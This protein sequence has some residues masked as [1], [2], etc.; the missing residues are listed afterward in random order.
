MGSLK[1]AIR[2]CNGAQVRRRYA[3]ILL[4]L[5][6]CIGVA[7]G[8]MFCTV[9]MK[10]VTTTQFLFSSLRLVSFSYHGPYR[11]SWV[12]RGVNILMVLW[13]VVGRPLLYSVHTHNG[14]D[15]F[16]N[17]SNIKTLNP[18][19]PEL[20]T[21]NLPVPEPLNRPQTLNPKS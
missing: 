19:S 9:L 17:P 7:T 15:D 14:A 1:E 11:L 13:A 4:N 18:Q 6:I 10:S 16:A 2:P 3:L 5:G 21:L 8:R 20:Y 12:T